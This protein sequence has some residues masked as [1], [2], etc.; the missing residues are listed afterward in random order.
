[1]A[2]PLLFAWGATA[3]V[4]LV[5]F[6][7]Y[8]YASAMAASPKP[9]GD[10]DALAKGLPTTFVEPAPYIKALSDALPGT[11]ILP[12]DVAEFSS[13]IRIWFAAQ[14]RDIIPAA[15]FRPRSVR[16][17]SITI[18]HI[19]KE[20]A[21]RA[22]LP[23]TGNG[24]FAIRAGGAN[25]ATGI[26]GVKDGIVIDLAL[27][28]TIEPSEDG[29]SVRVGGGAYW[30]DVYKTLDK[31]NL[32][33]VGGRAS[34]VGVG[35]STLQGGMS[36]FSPQ[37]GFICSNVISY[38]VVLADGSI[39]T[40][41]ASENRDLWLSLKGG[42]NNFGV[43]VEFELRCFPIPDKIW[44]A[45]FISPGFLSTRTITAFHEHAAQASSP[46]GFDEKA[47]VPILSFSYLP[48]VGATAHFCHIAYT[49]PTPDGK[50][51]EYWRKSPLHSLWRFQNKSKNAP[52][53]EVVMDLGVLSRKEER[54]V[55][56]TTTVKNDLETLMMV[57]QI[58]REAH[59]SVKHV[60]GTMFIYIMQP[61]YPQWANKGT[62]NVL[63]LEGLDET[64]V[65]VSFAVNW[66]NPKDDDAITGAVRRCFERI[67]EYAASKGTAHPYRFSNYSSE[68]Q[69]PLQ[70]CGAEN[71]RLMQNVSERY[72]PKGL[73]QTGCLG[74]FKLDKREK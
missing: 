26:S 3:L 13:F 73:F 23:A 40:A 47:S 58:W 64:L 28:N 7:I 68:W 63:G 22:S 56:G 49:E 27:I 67:E 38:Q 31:R 18:K 74:G 46:T 14:N 12:K 16:D 48:D 17:L 45:N 59:S 6:V 44:A 61:I 54:N 4:A 55:F 37:H 42:G 39:V 65:V 52:V 9:E 33:V 19:S 24:L 41:S 34:P 25:P 69:K 51:P 11:V 21:V 62:P 36:Y 71:M 32:G 72:D 53:H 10:P 30:R 66:P 50:W 43:V 2:P 35:G 1:M 15:V 8:Y 57:R 60:K 29:T 70:G 20:H 5:T